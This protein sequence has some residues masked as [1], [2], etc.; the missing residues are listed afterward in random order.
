MLNVYKDFKDIEADVRANV[1]QIVYKFRTW[2]EGNHKKIITNNELWLSHPFKLND[3]FDVRPPY[4]FIT[5]Q[6]DWNGVKEKIRMA[7]RHSVPGISN[8][9]LETEMEKRY[10]EMATDPVAYFA[11]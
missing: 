11:K 5:D 1:P 3:P 10:Q 9:Q 7:G 4:R 6:I 8:E 2:E